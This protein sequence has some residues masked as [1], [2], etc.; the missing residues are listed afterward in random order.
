MLDTNIVVDYLRQNPTVVSF[1]EDY[2][3]QNFALS[4]IVIMEI[5][6]GV[7]DKKDLDRTRKRLKGFA[8]LT[9]DQEIVS[10]ALSLQ[11]EY[12]LSHR[13]GI[14][15]SIIA[16][17]ALVFNLELRTFNMKDFRFIPTLKVSN[18]LE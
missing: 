9:L 8:T 11:L 3:K 2:G 10:L 18:S 16:A 15:D 6:Q 13:I 7:F 17:T 5:Y 1:I 14:P 4:P 12:V